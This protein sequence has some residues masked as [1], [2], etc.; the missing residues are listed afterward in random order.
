MVRV[1]EYNELLDLLSEEKVPITE[2]Y[3]LT[4]QDSFAAW[5]LVSKCGDVYQ[6]DLYSRIMIVSLKD[7]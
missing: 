2:L 7:G 5:Y 1:I 4:D 3:W 6:P